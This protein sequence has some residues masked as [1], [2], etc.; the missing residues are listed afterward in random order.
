[1]VLILMSPT[2]QLFFFSFKIHGV[3]VCVCVHLPKII[4]NLYKYFLTFCTR[5]FSFRFYIVA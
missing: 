3:C 5:Y 2:Y 4:K 1:M